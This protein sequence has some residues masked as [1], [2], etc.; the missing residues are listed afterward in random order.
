VL[1][2][3]KGEDYSRYRGATL[4]T[5]NRR[6]AEEAVGRRLGRIEEFSKAA[7]DLMAQADLD[8]AVITLG[9]GG[10][11]FK[12]RKGE[13]GHVPAQARAVFDVTGAGDT[14]IAQIAFHVADGRTLEA[15][16]E[17]ANHAAGI[18]VGRLGTPRRD[19][20]RAPGPAAGG[21][22]A[23]GEGRAQR[24]R[25]RPAPGRVAQGEEADRVHERAA[26]T[27]STSG[28]SN[29]FGSRRARAT[30]CSSP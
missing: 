16:V 14:V 1:V 25:A 18:V 6:E 9:G 22:S 20:Q 5:P 4:V 21:A 29:T 19:A 7:D 13:A 17:I 23:R 10:I 26:S 28:T 30:C 3:P 12:S 8:A 27:C 11:Y 15:A 2:D 24:G